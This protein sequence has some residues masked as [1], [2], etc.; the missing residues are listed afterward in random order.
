[1][2]LRP[3]Q[4]ATLDKAMDELHYD[5]DKGIFTWK[6]P[7]KRNQ[8][9]AGSEAGSL[10]KNGYMCIGIDGQRIYSHRLAWY[11]IYGHMPL[12]GIDHIDGN[13]LNNSIK[14][15]RQ[16]VHSENAQ[17]IKRQSNNTSG[18]TGV[19]WHKQ[20]GKWHAYVNVNKKRVSAGCF[21]DFD[22]AVNARIGLKAKLHK[23]NPSESKR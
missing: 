1:M 7:Q 8:I 23:F 18:H 16:A 19:H 21:N 15:L 13:K 12:S 2:I 9:K 3:Y 20:I 10:M 6:R 5:I 11:F 14:N 22:D 4:Q 17:N